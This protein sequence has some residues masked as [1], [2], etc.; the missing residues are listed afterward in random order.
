MASAKPSWVLRANLFFYV[1]PTRVTGR[2]W[3]LL[4]SQIIEV[5]LGFFS[6]QDEDL[7]VACPHRYGGSV[8]SWKA[9]SMNSNG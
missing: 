6:R 8:V 2:P 7:S 5:V 3:G 4:V 1:S 9:L